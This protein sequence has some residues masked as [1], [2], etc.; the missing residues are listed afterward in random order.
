VKSLFAALIMAMLATLP[1][2][3]QRTAVTATVQDPNGVP[4]ASGA[5]QANLDVSGVPVGR[6]VSFQGSN[7]FQTAYAGQLDSLGRFSVDLP[8][9]NVIAPPGATQW[10]FT[11][12][13]YYTTR[14]Q[15][16]AGCFNLVLAVTGSSMDIT[17]QVQAASVDIIAP[18]TT[19]VASGTVAL[20]TASITSGNCAPVITVSNPAIL[21]T[22]KGS[23]GWQSDPASVSGYGTSATGSVLTIYHWLEAGK[24]QIKVCN[25]SGGAITPGAMALGWQVER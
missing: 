25:S 16:P 2:F 19:H 18:L 23:L 6:S 21:A 14:T 7:A 5:W 9:N 22:D 1:C 15:S 17:T 3:G 12:C 10:A 13:R 8:D 11:F 4:Y 24:L 20:G